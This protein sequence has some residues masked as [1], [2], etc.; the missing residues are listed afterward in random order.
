MSF[1]VETLFPDL[2]KL[3]I[4]VQLVGR[5]AEDPSAVRRPF[6]QQAVSSFLAVLKARPHDIIHLNYGLFGFLAIPDFRSASI[7]HIHGSEV[8]PGND[9]RIRLANLVSVAFSKVVDSIWY[10]TPD[11]REHLQEAGLTATF[12]PN[13]VPR[14]FFQMQEPDFRKARIL[15]AVPLSMEK[16]ADIAISAVRVLQQRL[17][18]VRITALG[19]GPYPTE[20]MAL[21]MRLPEGVE[22]LPWMTRE[23]FLR[24]LAS[25]TVVVGQ[26][27]L[28]ILGNT[29]L[30]AMALG[31]P[32]VAGLK[33]E[34]YRN[35]P[36]YDSP[37]P[38][39]QAVGAEEVAQHVEAVI[40]DAANART[41][42]MKSHEWVLRH[43][44]VERV[45]RLYR[46]AYKSLSP[47]V[48]S[49]T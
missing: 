43:H 22:V 18:D 4:G 39:L 16:G 24:A 27:R 40:A 15:F 37:P 21:R 26:L 41:L 11:L 14:Q 8:R 36:H 38:I 28:Q 45:A 23:K 5:R 7:L 19:W 10:S 13:P 9:W 12:M 25:S 32:L 35:E 20:A 31:R 29:E 17:P 44:S 1:I 46:E 34:V 48:R 6:A 3:G 2:I 30:E 33:D 49:T 42:G 47:E